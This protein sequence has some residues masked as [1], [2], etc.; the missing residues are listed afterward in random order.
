MSVSAL[1]AP[2]PFETPRMDRTGSRTAACC[3][4]RSDAKATAAPSL[5]GRGAGGSPAPRDDHLRPAAAQASAYAS[6]QISSIVY[7]PSATTVSLILSTVT[8]TGS[9][10]NDGMATPLA[11]SAVV[12][13][14]GDS[15]LASATASSAA[16]YA[17]GL[18][19]L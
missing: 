14:S 19:A 1:T 12:S 6:V 16:L 4:S 9:S 5:C 17:S 11:V 8:A 3:S 7:R 13:A 10:R 18:N 15:P 2:K